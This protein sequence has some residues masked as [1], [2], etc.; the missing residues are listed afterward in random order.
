MYS[1]VTRVTTYI[2]PMG[3]WYDKKTAVEV[4]NMRLWQ[5]LKVHTLEPP[6]VLA[7]HPEIY[8]G[9]A[10]HIYMYM[11]IQCNPSNQDTLK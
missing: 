10:T 11:Y 1:S 8:M 9:G 2:D 7:R 4:V 5:Q 3:A 6:L